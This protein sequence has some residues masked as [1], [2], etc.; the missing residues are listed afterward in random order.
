MGIRQKKVL[1]LQKFSGIGLLSFV[2]RKRPKDGVGAYS[3]KYTILNYL[4]FHSVR[5][6]IYKIDTS[7]ME[8]YIYTICP[9]SSDPFKI[10]TYYIKWSLLLTAY[11][12]VYFKCPG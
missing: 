7:C 6:N 11:Q 4:Q 3:A 8:N 9:R 2:K 10:I 1:K 12:S 5:T